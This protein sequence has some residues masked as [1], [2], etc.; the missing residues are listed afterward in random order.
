MELIGQLFDL[1]LHLDKH[2]A[3][4]VQAHGGWIYFLLFMIVFA[5][6]GLVITPFLPGDSLL[7][8]AGT[9]AAA[10][11][12]NV[13]LL[14]VLLIIAAILGDTV[15]YWVGHHIGPRVFRNRNARF[16]KPAYLDYTH[17]FF[18][19]HGGK[20][21]IIGRFLPIIR[22]FAPFV[23][24]AGSMTYSRFLFYNVAGAVLWVVSL[25]LAGYL[26]GNLKIVQEN[27]TLVIIGII[28]LS[29]VPGFVEYLRHRKRAD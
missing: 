19:R 7:F 12:M 24:G 25:V 3:A 2:L 4:F 15:N 6:T 22:T 29:L 17:A 5:E 1:V 8:V 13:G 14:M 26:F 20:T 10:G 28:I 18:E 21:I 11:G 9:L 27:L 16:F 23:A